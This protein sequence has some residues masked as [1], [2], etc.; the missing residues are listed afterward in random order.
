MPLGSDFRRRAMTGKHRYVVAKRKYF[1]PDSFQQE[2][3]ISTGQIAPADAAGKEDVATD[4]QLIFA[5]KKAKTSGAMARDFEHLHFQ[6]KKFPR[7]RL[8]NEEV[9]FDRL[10]LQMKPKAAK[11]FRIGNHW[12][13]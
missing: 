6:P 11:E 7:R 5:R 8:F 9:G 3:N 1:F 10:D 12:G 4:Q 2:I 13:G